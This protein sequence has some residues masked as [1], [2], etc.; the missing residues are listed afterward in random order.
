L[1]EPELFGS[2][3]FFESFCDWYVRYV[4]TPL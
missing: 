3:D 4:L 1:P 2:C